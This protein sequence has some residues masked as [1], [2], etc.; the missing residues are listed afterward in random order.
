VSAT[1]AV[2]VTLQRRGHRSA[3]PSPSPRRHA[4]PTLDPWLNAQA[5]NLR[6]HAAALG[7]LRR[8]EFE[9]GAATVTEGHIQATNALIESLRRQLLAVTGE[10]GAATTQARRDRT[11]PSIQR[12]M[13]RKARGHDW[14]MAI[15]RVWDFYFELFTQRQSQFGSWLVACD[16]IALSCYQAAYTGIDSARPVPAPGPFCYMRTGFSPATFRRGL[17]LRQLGRLP[18]PFPLI[19]L[20]YH[21]LVNPWTLGAVLHEVCHNLQ[22][23]LGLARVLPRRIEQRLR[24]EGLPASVARVYRRWNRE[25]F[26]DL[27]ALL[28]GGPAVVASLM[29]VVGRT[30]SMVV[31]YSATGPHPTPWLRV[32]LSCELLRRMGF[33]AE[34]AAY[35][36]AWLRSYPDGRAGTI[37][38]AVVRTA[39]EAIRIVVDTVCYRP[40]RSLGDKPLAA[41]IRFRPK[42]QA[43]AEQ[44]AKRLAA[45]T[46]PGVVPPRYLI[47]AA[48]IALD[49][50]YARPGVIARRF[51]EELAGR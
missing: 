12:L 6:R 44:A 38:E 47:G 49:R 51:Y 45:G 4:P 1:P 14:V 28:L 10:V 33:P 22:N 25:T 13:V 34:A 21:R 16:R 39:P 7:P 30:P 15:E 23:D 35:R 19:Q 48:R 41:C 43:L 46:D 40:Y 37:P 3:A 17:R 20:P 11:T 5:I 9:A 31:G 29:D 26:A 42:D 18:N 8:E 36:R 27:G 32:Q 50:H 2:A 24:T